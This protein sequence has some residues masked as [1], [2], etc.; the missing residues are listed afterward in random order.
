MSRSPRPSWPRQGHPSAHRCRAAIRPAPAGRTDRDDA[1]QSLRR[2]SLTLSAASPTLSLTRRSAVDLAL[3]LQV[4]SS[5]RSPAASFIRPFASST[6]P[7]PPC[8][9]PSRRNHCRRI[10]ASPEHP[11]TRRVVDA[12]ARRSGVRGR[13]PCDAR[14][15]PGRRRRRRRPRVQAASSRRAR[16]CRPRVQAASSRR[17]R[18]SISTP[19]K[20]PASAVVRVQRQ[21]V[22]DVLVGAHDDDAARRRGRRRAGRRCRRPRV[23]AEGLLVVDQAERA[24]PRQQDRRQSRRRPARGGPAGRRRGRRSPRPGRRRPA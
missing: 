23:G 12:P 10:T 2:T 19:S 11:S 22:R 14:R 7:S 15:S 18:A 6:L 16:A 8:Q 1:A 3:V 4:L 20:K 24:L 17:T 21:H 13:R 5:V 9:S